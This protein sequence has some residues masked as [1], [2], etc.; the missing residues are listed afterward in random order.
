MNAVLRQVLN[1]TQGDYDELPD[2]LKEMYTPRQWQ[3]L[4]D[5]E[6]AGLV[7]QSTEPEY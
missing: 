3:F 1:P 5:R 7:Q 2:Y 4:S 6:K